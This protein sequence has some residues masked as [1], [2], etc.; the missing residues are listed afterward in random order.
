MRVNFNEFMEPQSNLLTRAP[1]DTHDRRRLNWYV[2]RWNRR[3]RKIL[4]EDIPYFNDIPEVKGKGHY[5]KEKKL[6]VYFRAAFITGMVGQFKF[7]KP[8]D[9]RLEDI[10]LNF[11]PSAYKITNLVYGAPCA[12]KFKLNL[13]S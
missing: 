10:V 8:T 2:D 4:K 13:Y 3:V 5:V 11:K 1:A 9:L 6:E 7:V 12:G